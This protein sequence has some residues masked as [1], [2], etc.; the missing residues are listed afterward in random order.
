MCMFVYEYTRTYVNEYTHTFLVLF[1]D[2]LVG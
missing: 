2:V 1:D